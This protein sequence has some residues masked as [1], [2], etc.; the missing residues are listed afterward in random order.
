VTPGKDALSWATAKYLF[1]LMAYKD[2]YEVARLYTD[3]SFRQQLART[4]DGDYKLEFHLAPPVLSKT[5]PATGRPRKIRF[6][7]WMMTLFGL[8]AKMKGLRGTRFDPFGY[9]GDRKTE[10]KLIADYEALLDEIAFRLRPDTHETAVALASLPEQIR[11]YGPVKAA[12]IE[13][14]KLREAELLEALRR[15][16]GERQRAA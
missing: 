7:P 15:A 2:E 14:A 8:L 16:P 13:R 5:D 9:S 10:R 12:A 11:G 4:F 6:G 1:K 3:G